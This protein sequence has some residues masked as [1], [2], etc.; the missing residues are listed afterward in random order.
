MSLKPGLQ[1]RAIILGRIV[2][3]KHAAEKFGLLRKFGFKISQDIVINTINTP[4]RVD[5]KGG[6]TFS[7][8]FMNEEYALRVV[9]EERNGVILVITFYPVRRERYGL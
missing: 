8:K 5:R 6:Q 9:H 4:D 3:T 2:Y 1:L 7:M